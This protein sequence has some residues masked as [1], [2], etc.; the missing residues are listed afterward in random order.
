MLLG[1]KRPAQA[2]KEFEASAL[3]NPRRFR[4]NYGAALAAAQ[5]GDMGRARAS[6]AKLLELAAKGELRP[7][8]EQAKSWLARN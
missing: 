4:G 3:D 1:L 5:A 2:L 8:L 6:Y 7:E